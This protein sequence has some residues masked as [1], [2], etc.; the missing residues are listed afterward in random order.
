MRNKRTIYENVCMGHGWGARRVW[1]RMGK[2]LSGYELIVAW[3]E[4]LIG[5]MN[6]IYVYMHT[7]KGLIVV[8]LDCI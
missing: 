3:V 2:L 7:I 5:T 4:G 8:T 6:G 1:V